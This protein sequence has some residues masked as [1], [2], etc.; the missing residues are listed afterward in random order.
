MNWTWLSLGTQ[1]S[2][3]L[4]VSSLTVPTGAITLVNDLVV[5]AIFATPQQ[6]GYT[7]TDNAPGGGNTYTA[8]V[9][10]VTPDTL[11]IAQM[12][13]AR[14]MHPSHSPVV[15][16]SVGLGA[17]AAFNLVAAVYRSLHPWS[18]DFHDSGNGHGTVLG[19]NT[20]VPTGPAGLLVM[21]GLTNDPA[22][23]LVVLNPLQEVNR[24]VLAGAYRFSYAHDRTVSTSITPEMD[25][26]VATDFA[27][28]IY[29]WQSAAPPPPPT[30]K[31]GAF[32]PGGIQP[33][34]VY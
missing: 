28:A 18:I 26:T 16:V 7:V 13:Q 27:W 30:I 24:N 31:G 5:V 14:V 17:P 29:D 11:A 9:A 1:D 4:P 20:Y 23:P 15:N 33:G 21:L 34:P 2:G 25:N 6:A 19:G 3:G 8:A 22:H 32:F 10:G 12:Y